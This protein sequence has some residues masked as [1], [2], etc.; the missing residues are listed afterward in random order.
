M[1]KNSLLPISLGLMLIA[2]L[3]VV[4]LSPPGE[5]VL[6]FNQNNLIRVAEVREVDGKYYY[7]RVAPVSEFRP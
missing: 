7:R 6:A 1:H 5:T 3:L 2:V 4:F